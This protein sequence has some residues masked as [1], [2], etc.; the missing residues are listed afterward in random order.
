MDRRTLL[1]TTGVLA[2]TGVVAACGGSGETGSAAAGGVDASAPESG[3]ASG[4]PGALTTGD[5]PVGGGVVLDESAVVVVQPEAGTFLAFTAVCPHQGCLVSSV[6]NNEIVCPCHDSIFSAVDGSVIQG[7]A[8]QGL[9]SAA[10][11]VDGENIT[12]G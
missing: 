9:A 4:P 12:A 3:A 6:A 11:T 5:V 1:G 10:I 2:A 7:P 8:L